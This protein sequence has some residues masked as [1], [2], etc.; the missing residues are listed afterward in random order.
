MM[1][2]VADS[3]PLHYLILLDQTSLLHRFYGDVVVSD[4]VAGELCAARS[5]QQVRDWMSHPPDWLQL[6][7][8]TAEEIASVVDALDLDERAAIALTERVQADF[9]LIDE[10]DGREKLRVVA[11]ESPARWACCEPRRRKG[12]W[13]SMTCSPD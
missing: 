6:I 1:I 3:G 4:V 7:P 2:V 13:T 8:V 9:V 12:S 10:T 5:L 11:S